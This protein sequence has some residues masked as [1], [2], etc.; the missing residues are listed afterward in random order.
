[1]YAEHHPQTD[2]LTATSVFSAGAALP[3]TTNIPIALGDWQAHASV[4]SDNNPWDLERILVA[5]PAAVPRLRG[6]TSLEP[7]SDIGGSIRIP[8]A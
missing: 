7:G 1:M 2:N 4:Q 3:S 8:A 5:A 6:M